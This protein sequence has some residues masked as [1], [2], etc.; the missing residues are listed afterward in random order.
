MSFNCRGLN[1]N[2]KRAAIFAHLRQLD[3]QIILLQETF[4]KPC[5]GAILTDEWTSGQAIFNSPSQN[6]KMAS[7]TAILLNHPALIFGPI[8]K[9]V[10]GRVVAAEV[11]HNGFVIIVINIYAPVSCLSISVRKDFFKSLYNDFHPNMVNILGGDFN[12]MDDPLFDVHPPNPKK[13][14]ITELTDLCG[15][16]DL[17]DSFRTFY[18]NK[19]SFMWRGPHSVSRLARIYV[20]KNVEI[21][22]ALMKPSPHSDYDMAITQLNIP[23]PDPR[24]KVIGRTTY[25]YINLKSFRKS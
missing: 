19:Q 3:A 21:I 4:S 16:C 23:L 5:K 2:A 20:N 8:K 22:Q 25:Q 13:T 15:T 7:W 24:E 1:N 17:Q 18:P 14:Q 11:K 6:N 12:T 10:D 9:D